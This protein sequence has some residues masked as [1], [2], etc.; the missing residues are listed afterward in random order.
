MFRRW[1]KTLVTNRGLAAP[2]LRARLA[3]PELEAGK[4]SGGAPRVA[5]VISSIDREAVAA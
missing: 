5:D 4:G 1:W 3:V 2:Y